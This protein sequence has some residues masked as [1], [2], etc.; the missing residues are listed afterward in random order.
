MASVSISN[1]DEL[2]HIITFLSFGAY[3]VDLN[4][5]QKRKFARKA[6]LFEVHDSRLYYKRNDG[7]LLRFFADHQKVDK[8][9]AIMSRHV[10]LAHVRRDKMLFDLKDKI[11]NVKREEVE[12]VLECCTKCIFMRKLKTRQ[13]SRQIVASKIAERYQADLIDL[14]YYT[15]ANDQYCWILNIID[16]YSKYLMSVPLKGKS[17]E[18]VKNGFKHIFDIFGEPLTLQTDNGKEFKNKTLDNYLEG[19]NVSRVYG[20]ARH[21]Q[22]NGQVERCNQTLKKLICGLI[23]DYKGSNTRW[24]DAHSS[25]VAT[26]NSTI[27]RAHGQT[28][29]KVFFKR[30]RGNPV[31]D[32]IVIQNDIDDLTLIDREIVAVDPLNSINQNQEQHDDENNVETIEIL[33]LE[34]VSEEFENKRLKYFQQQQEQST[35]KTKSGPVYAK[36]VKVALYKDFDNNPATRK[37]PFELET[38]GKI[39]EIVKIY[40]NEFVD[41]KAIDSEEIHHYVDGSRIRI[42]K[43]SNL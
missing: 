13:V 5:S 39:Y 32:R 34:S 8:L 9:L 38:D 15:N 17:A 20:R 41:I 4:V 43:N 18:L 42:I 2:N 12:E 36:G 37:R 7:V 16:I 40:E 29:F 33:N 1:A 14:R 26:Y 6:H 35:W 30:D 23:S 3:P 19:L 31:M 24:I 25:A 21:P 28:P 11:Y 22:S 27:H 10:A